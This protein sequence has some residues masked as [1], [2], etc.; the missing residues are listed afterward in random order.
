M[1]DSFSFD[2]GKMDLR[3]NPFEEGEYDV[4]RFQHRP[5]WIMDTVQGGDLVDQLDLT[6]VFS[7]DHAN[8]LIIYA[9][10]DELRPADDTEDKL[11][12]AEES[13]HEPKPAEESVH[14]P[15][16]AEVRVDEL[17]ELS[18]TT[19]ELDELSGTTLELSELSDTKDG[20]GLAAGRNGPCSAQGKVHKRCN[21]NLFLSKF[22][23]PFPQSI[24]SPFS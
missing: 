18:D 19:L 10:L 13:V 11:K 23:Q 8:S 20:A 6:E 12:Q 5:A 2:S 14:E 24:S 21:I 17:S 16:P 15:K 22:D 9:T 7:S 3:T 1:S 4:S